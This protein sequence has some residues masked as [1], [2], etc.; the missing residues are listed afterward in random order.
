MPAVQLPGRRGS[1]SAAEGAVAGGR[2]DSGRDHSGSGKPT[3]LHCVAG[4]LVPTPVL[5]A[6]VRTHGPFSA[7]EE[8]PD[9][10]RMPTAVIDQPAQGAEPAGS[11][12]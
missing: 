2:G 6:A 11:R 5:P 4:I 1:P 9:N 8:E 7:A 10:L 12:S 3:L